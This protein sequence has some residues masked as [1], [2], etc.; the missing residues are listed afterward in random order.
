MNKN[1]KEVEKLYNQ[2]VGFCM[3]ETNQDKQDKMFKE[4]GKLLQ[5]I[6]MIKKGGV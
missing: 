3:E 1:I 4:M 5:I 6:E 2:Y